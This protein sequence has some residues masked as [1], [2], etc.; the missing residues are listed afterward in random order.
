[1]TRNI[2]DQVAPDYEKIHN[3][4]LPPGVRSESFIIQRAACAT[5]WIL[6]RI[7]YG[8][9]SYLDFGCGN[10]RM[11]KCL[12]ES[13][14]LRPFLDTGRLHLF[15]FD[16]SAD[17]LNEARTLLNDESVILAENWCE[18][19]QGLCFDLV[20]SCHVFHHIPPKERPKTAAALYRRMKPGSRLVIFEQNPLNPATRLLV[21]ACPF[22]RD[23]RLLTATETRNLFLKNSFRF[24]DQAYINLL[25][26]QWVK[27]DCLAAIEKKLLSFPIGAQYWIMFQ[28]GRH[29]G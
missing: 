15:G 13:S 19:P 2:F 4:S 8:E 27:N 24:L 20:V 10:G 26:P 9:F 7:S 25:P 22:D 28:R 16:T 1:M 17:S 21:K 12:L 29:I 14:V 3:Q 11:L 18:F 23:A 6:S 5:E